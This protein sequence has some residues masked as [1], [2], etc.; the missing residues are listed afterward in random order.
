[1]VEISVEESCPTLFRPVQCKVSNLVEIQEENATTKLS[2][3]VTDIATSALRV[4]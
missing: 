1:M 2:G 3:M 4:L